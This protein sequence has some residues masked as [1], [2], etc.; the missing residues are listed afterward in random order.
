VAVADRL[1]QRAAVLGDQI[2]EHRLV[3]GQR[4]QPPV[5]PEALEHGGGTFD[6]RED[7]GDG[8]HAH[9]LTD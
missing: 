9:I 2:A 1:D 7:H 4:S 8:G 6:V 3:L 5:V